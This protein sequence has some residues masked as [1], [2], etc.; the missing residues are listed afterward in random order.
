MWARLYDGRMVYENL[1]RLLCHSTNPN[2][3]DTHPPFQIDGNFGGVSA[4]AEAL[5]QSVSGEIIL[6]P[7]LPDEWREGSVK[8]LRAKGGF[9]VDISWRDNRL[10]SAVITSD[11]GGEC[12][13]RTNCVASLVCDGENVGSRIE[14]GVIIFNTEAGRKYTVKA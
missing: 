9:G 7:A 8:G 5:L 1:K 10:T 14:N 13:L 12:R 11:L 2:L 3:L 4:V 6:L